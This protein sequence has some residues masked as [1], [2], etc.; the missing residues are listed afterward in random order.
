MIAA[1][2]GVA[3]CI[4]LTGVLVV[5]GC[6]NCAQPQS[7]APAAARDP[8]GELARCEQLY[9]LYNR[10]RNTGGETPQGSSFQGMLEA[11]NALANCRRG[12]T[13]EGIAALERKVGRGG[14]C[15]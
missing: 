2:R 12:N 1:V 5:A 11:E 15:S 7:A 9:A 10:Y 14:A 13:K 6:S 3:P 4:G 8:A